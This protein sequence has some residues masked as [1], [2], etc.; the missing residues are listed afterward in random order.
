MQGILLAAG[1]GRRFQHAENTQQDKLLAN[2]PNEQTVLFQ[3]ASALIQALPNSLAVVQPHQGARKKVLQNL[4]F[5]IVESVLAEG[6]MGY[7]ISDA[8]KA[9]KGAEGWLVALA[10]M[11]WISPVLIQQLSAEVVQPN[12][13]AVPRF[14]GKRGQ[15]VAF[16][17]AWLEKL[18]ALAGDVGARHILKTAAINWVDWHDGSIHQDV[19]TPRDVRV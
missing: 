9:T 1:F 18:V 17:P 11:P 2:L 5:S 13:I 3:S 4:G 6:G 14:N 15:P 16:G 19:D 12:T 7:A 8:V 10:D